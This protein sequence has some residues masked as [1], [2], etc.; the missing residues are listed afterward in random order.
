LENAL[1]QIDEKDYDSELLARGIKKERNRY[2]GFAFRGK[3][4]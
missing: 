1:H 3:K 4:F 2:Y